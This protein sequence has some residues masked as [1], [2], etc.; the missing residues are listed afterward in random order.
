MF[1]LFFVL[2]FSVLVS[3]C[4]LWHMGVKG[5][6]GEYEDTRCTVMLVCLLTGTGYCTLFGNK[7]ILKKKKKI[8]QPA[9]TMGEH[10]QF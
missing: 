10:T 2:F 9:V 4:L 1:I 5:S 7:K 8:G 6:D 3:F